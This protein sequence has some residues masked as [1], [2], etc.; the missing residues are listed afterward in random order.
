MKYHCLSTSAQERIKSI[1]SYTEPSSY[2]EA[3]CIP[4]WVE[5]MK[6]EFEALSKNNTWDLVSLPTGKKVIGSKWVYKVKLKADG[7]QER[8]KARLV[9]IG[10]S[11]KEGEDFTETFSPVV[12]MASV[13]TLIAVAAYRK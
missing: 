1:N 8:F 12:K 6:L 13:R 4:E 9:A 2:K 11:Q 5:V 10:Y 7:S 3:A